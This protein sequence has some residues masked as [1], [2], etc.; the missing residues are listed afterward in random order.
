MNLVP[1]P[2]RLELAR[3]LYDSVSD[4]YNLFNLLMLDPVKRETPK[5]TR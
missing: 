5:R 4:Y 2:R 1:S 3:E